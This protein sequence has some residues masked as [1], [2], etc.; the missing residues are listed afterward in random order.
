[1]I[2]KRISLP[3]E[4]DRRIR[5]RVKRLN[6]PEEQVIRKLIEEGLMRL[7]SIRGDNPSF[8]DCLV[9]VT[10]NQYQTEDI[11][12]FDETFRKNGYTLPTDEE[13]KDAA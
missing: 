4:L 7:Q 9:M 8:I 13:Q 11:F 10:A 2:Q 6:Q 5:E 12:G 3:E 1:M